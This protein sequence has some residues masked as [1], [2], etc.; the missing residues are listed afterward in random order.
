MIVLYI[1]A[2]VINGNTF[3]S[4]RKQGHYHK[5]DKK[6]LYFHWV[7]AFLLAKYKLI[8]Q[9]TKGLFA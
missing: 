1:S 5:S 9:N 8:N 6:D 4:L 7:I 3:L 2:K